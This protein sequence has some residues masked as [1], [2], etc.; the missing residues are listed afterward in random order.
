MLAEPRQSGVELAR[1]GLAEAERLE[2]VALV[3]RVDVV[4]VQR[5]A[6]QHRRDARGRR[7]RRGPRSSRRCGSAPARRRRRARARRRPSRRAGS[8]GS[9]AAGSPAPWC[10][11]STV[12]SAGAA[13][14]RSRSRVAQ[15]SAVRWPGGEADRQ[16][17]LGPG[18]DDRAHLDGVAAHHAVDVEGRVGPVARVVLGARVRVRSAASA[19]R[20]RA[21]RR[22]PAAA[23][24]RRA[25]RGSAAG[26]RRAAPPAARPSGPGS[27][28]ASIRRAARGTR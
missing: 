24:T 17:G 3:G 12:A 6:A 18:R 23:P 14:R 10:T 5:E 8:A 1:R 7:T 28:L 13:S 19:D 20:G 11:T 21:R 22:R 16:L 9:K 15:A 27:T 2:P 26:S 25:P 4:L